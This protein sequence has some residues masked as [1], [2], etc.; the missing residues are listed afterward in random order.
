MTTFVKLPERG[1]L[2]ISGKD[3]RP[4]LQGLITNDINLLDRQVCLYSCLLSANGKFLFDFFITEEADA[5]LLDC[6]GGERA[7]ALMHHLKRYQLRSQ[8][9]LEVN[10]FAEIFAIL[11]PSSSH[12]WAD[13]RHPKMGTRCFSPPREASEA[14][15]SAWDRHRIGLNI[16]DG[17]RD[18]IPERATLLESNIDRLNGISWDKGCYMGQ[19]LTARMYYRGLAKKHLTALEFQETP[20]EPLTPLTADG[21]VIGE[22]RSSCGN[23]GIALIKDAEQNR[24]EEF[25]AKVI[26]VPSA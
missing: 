3:R 8:I 5:L 18:M 6:E 24:V 7:E 20:L 22:M 26:H 9:N 13:P 4:F 1:L 21:K 19:E 23:L 14:P 12:G 10:P 25:G 17:S 16:P 2:S 11:P 15:F